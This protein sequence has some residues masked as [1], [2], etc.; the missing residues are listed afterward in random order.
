MK[1]GGDV[2]DHRK[3]HNSGVVWSIKGFDLKRGECEKYHGGC[4]ERSWLDKGWECLQAVQST[5]SDWD[6]TDSRESH[7]DTYLAR[8]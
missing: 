4:C 8:V 5:W 6:N 3:A 1:M 7:I 2:D